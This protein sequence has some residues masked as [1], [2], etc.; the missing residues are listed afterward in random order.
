MLRLLAFP[1]VAIVFASQP[2]LAAGA[3]RAGLSLSIHARDGQ[4][5]GAPLALELI[6]TNASTN[7]LRI[8]ETNPYRDYKV[9][10]WDPYGRR[11]P[12]TP[13]AEQF[14]ENTNVS[15][16]RNIAVVLHPGEFATDTIDLTKLLAIKKPGAYRVV[17]T[18]DA[19]QSQNDE[20]PIHVEAE[21]IVHI[22]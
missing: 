3:S 20:H 2:L 11:V 16:D 4:P 6:I 13:F 17:V 15:L 7:D 19:P 5:V 18:R 1:V 12:M 9:T 14:N 10:G 21:V 22:K 8:A